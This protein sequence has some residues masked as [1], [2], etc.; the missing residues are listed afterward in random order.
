MTQTHTVPKPTFPMIPGKR[1]KGQQEMPRP[2]HN[3]PYEKE[4]YFK[5]ILCSILK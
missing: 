1:Y 4:V 2:F 5:F 3:S